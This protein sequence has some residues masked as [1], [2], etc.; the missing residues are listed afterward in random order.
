MAKIA[1]KTIIEFHLTIQLSEQE[2]R[3]LE[4]LAGYGSKEFLRIFYEYMGRHY[5]E[6]H[7]AGLISLFDIIRGTVPGFLHRVDDARETFEGNKS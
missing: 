4:A 3:A 1:T 2:A 5:L 6:P 7:E